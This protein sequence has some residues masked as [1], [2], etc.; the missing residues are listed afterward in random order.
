[1]TYQSDILDN[2][3]EK[4]SRRERLELKV[5]ET[6]KL[7]NQYK[8]VLYSLPERGEV[9]RIDG[10]W[11]DIYDEVKRRSAIELRNELFI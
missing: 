11:V 7:L 5:E 10:V 9:Y 8:R 1:M 3:V 6:E 4:A 2:L